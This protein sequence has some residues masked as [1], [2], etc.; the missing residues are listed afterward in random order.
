VRFSAGENGL[1]LPVAELETPCVR[2]DPA[3]L[4]VLDRYAAER[5]ERAPRSDSV[6]DRGRAA[7]AEE[8]RAGEPSAATLAARLKMSVRTLNRSLGAEGTSYRR[9]LDQLR[10]ELAIHHLADDRL[11]IAEVAFLLGFSELSAFYRAFKRW[12]GRTPAELRGRANT[13]Q[14]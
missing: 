9:I 10:R 5:V 11:T 2:A 4:A 6:A 3:L 7:L 13:R 14:S 8:L 12:T 1:R